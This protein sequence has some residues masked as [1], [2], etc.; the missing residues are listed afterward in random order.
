MKEIRFED[1]NVGSEMPKLV[2][3]PIDQVQLVKY[4][5][6]SG[7]FHPLHC[8]PAFGKKVGIGQIAHGMLVMGFAGE[9]LTNWI[10]KKHLRKLSVRF[11]GMTR[12]GD[13]VI[14]TGKITEKKQEGEQYI[15]WGE[16]VARN[17]KDEMLLSGSFEAARLDT[18]GHK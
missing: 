2:K 15:V 5:G 8:D 3:L 13:V 10:S 17:Q 4:A 1:L 12:P 11:V 7:D 6:A 14:V 18:S 9:A 16:I